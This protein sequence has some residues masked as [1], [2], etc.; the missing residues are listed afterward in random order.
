MTLIIGFES[1]SPKPDVTVVPT[2]EADYALALQALYIDLSGAEVAFCRAAKRQFRAALGESLIKRL[3]AAEFEETPLWFL[4]SGVA[5]QVQAPNGDEHQYQSQATILEDMVRATA[6]QT[7]QYVREDKPLV[8][9]NALE[10][11]IKQVG[12]SL[13]SFQLKQ[14]WGWAK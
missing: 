3:V 14:K 4:T 7:F 10:T 11:S 8:L 2:P 5:L 12:E 13:F 9:V 1:S 6:S